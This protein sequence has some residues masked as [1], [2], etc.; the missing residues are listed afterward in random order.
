MGTDGRRTGKDDG[1]DHGGQLTRQRQPQHT[2]HRPG[3][4]QLGK[5]PH[6]LKGDQPTSVARAHRTWACHTVPPQGKQYLDCEDHA[7]KACC[8]QRDPQGAGSHKFQL[9]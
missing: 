7:D 8:E 2:P 5:L 3:E 1:G 6:K 9:L 4:S